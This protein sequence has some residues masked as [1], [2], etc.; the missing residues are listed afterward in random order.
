MGPWVQRE[1]Q[2][3]RGSASLNLKLKRDA[4][5]ALP[6]RLPVADVVF[7]LVFAD[8]WKTGVSKG[9]R[10]RFLIYGILRGIS[11]ILAES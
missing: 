6:L 11:E 8:G 5:H 9:W 4:W 3:N 7:S 1:R 10:S 2:T